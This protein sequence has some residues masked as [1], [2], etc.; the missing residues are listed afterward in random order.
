MRQKQSFNLLLLLF[1]LL[2]SGNS[3]AA[4]RAPDFNLPTL[5]GKY[6]SLADLKGKV[7]YV[8]F[9]A[10]WCPPCRVSFPWMQTM[11]KRYSEAGLA[12]IAIN[13]DGERSL[14]DSFLKSTP[15]DFTIAHD[16]KG[17]SAE[18]YKVKGMPSSYIV[19]RNGFIQT[20]HMGFRNKDKDLLEAKIKAALSK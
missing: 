16:P 13:L 4:Q 19:D 20:T 8:D 12:I 18:A 10:T 7:V 6:V 15:V 5:N 3:S 14:I 17:I 9:W 1:I 11:H 2:F